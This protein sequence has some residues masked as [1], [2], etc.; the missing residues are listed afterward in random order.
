MVHFVG[1]GCG[2][3]DLITVRGARLIAGA[4]VLI[5]AGSLVN[6]EVLKYAGSDCEIHDS[7][8]L[9]LEQ[10]IEIVKNAEARSKT[11][12]RLHTGDSSIYGAVREQFDLL[13]SLG[14]AYDVCPGVS[15]FCGAAASLKAEYTL[16]CFY[17]PSCDECGRVKGRLAASPA[18][19]GMVGE[20][21]LAVLSVNVAGDSGAWRDAA[22]PEGWT[23]GCDVGERLVRGAVYDLKAM[24]TLYLLD[25]EKRVLLKDTS[26]GRL[27]AKLAGA[28]F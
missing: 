28:D 27:E 6:P 18:V 22:V 11:T 15:S 24:P 13:E 23:D 1:A 26:V 4:D 16:L 20:G 12:V 3:P 8:R 25:R 10:V 9:T 17:D 2:A 14:I 19:C 7:A 21:R 5:Y